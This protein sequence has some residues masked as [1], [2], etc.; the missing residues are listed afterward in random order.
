[1]FEGGKYNPKNRWNCRGKNDGGNHETKGGIAH[2]IRDNNYLA[3]AAELVADATIRVPG[4]Y[5][6]W[7]RAGPALLR[8]MQVSEESPTRHSDPQVIGRTT[9]TT[10]FIIVY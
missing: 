7:E 5:N 4:G 10:T 9:P 8:Q 1:L 6:G 3:E 2:M